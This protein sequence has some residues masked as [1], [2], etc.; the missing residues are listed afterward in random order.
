[1]LSGY[2]IATLVHAPQAEY[3]ILGDSPPPWVK[4]K[5]QK[6]IHD[7]D[8]LW[9]TKQIT[10]KY[11][12]RKR[13]LEL[14]QS[15]DEQEEAEVERMDAD[16]P[17]VKVEEQPAA[18]ATTSSSTSS[19]TKVGSRQRKKPRSDQKVESPA[20]SVKALTRSKTNN[21]VQPSSK[22]EQLES[23]VVQQ[24]SLICSLQTQLEKTL[25]EWVEQSSAV[26]ELSLSKAELQEKLGRLNLL[27]LQQLEL[28]KRVEEMKT[29]EKDSADRI[30]RLKAKLK[31]A[32]EKPKSTSEARPLE[33]YSDE[34]K[35]TQLR[36]TQPG[37][38]EFT[39]SVANANRS[40]SSSF[41]CLLFQNS[42]SCP[43]ISTTVSPICRRTRESSLRSHRSRECR[44]TV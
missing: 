23:Q 2:G 28:S 42:L 22:E 4:L 41:L 34:V 29:T 12:I 14:E 21:L 39:C 32:K 9:L 8:L 33:S 37:S 5:G 20:I 17:I 30:L 43:R 6:V 44:M 13:K 35:I 7:P 11:H 19:S 10:S 18:A 27:N 31:D 38:L 3:I 40:T 1:M 15:E 24:Q 25:S 36:T 26:V 16:E